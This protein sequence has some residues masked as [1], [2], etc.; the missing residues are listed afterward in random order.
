MLKYFF[1]LGIFLGA[2]PGVIQMIFL[3]MA[4]GRSKQ[5]TLVYGALGHFTG[6]IKN[7]FNHHIYDLYTYCVYI[8]QHCTKFGAF[9]SAHFDDHLSQY[10]CVELRKAIHQLED[11]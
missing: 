4:L 2:T 9:F 3:L 1:Q 6:E 10:R 5:P 11:I 7:Y 8:S